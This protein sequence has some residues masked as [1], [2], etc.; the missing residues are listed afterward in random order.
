MKDWI[1]FDNSFE[2]DK[3][4]NACLWVGFLLLFFNLFFSIPGVLQY[5]EEE[6]R[7]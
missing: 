7:G 1:D 3:M 4:T 5:V 2:V 6:K